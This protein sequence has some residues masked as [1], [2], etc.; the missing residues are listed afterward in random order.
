VID[1]IVK[2]TLRLRPPFQLGLPKTVALGAENN[3]PRVKAALPV[4]VEV[5]VN[6][7]VVRH[8][9]DVRGR[10]PR[11]GGPVGGFAVGPVIL[12]ENPMRPRRHCGR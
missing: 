10:M 6:L 5:S 11:N 1:A 8:S 12:K 9:R 4:G 2:G 3:M 7:Y